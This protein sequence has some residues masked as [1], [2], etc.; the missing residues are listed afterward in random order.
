M[1]R[2]LYVASL[3]LF[4]THGAFADTSPPGTPAVPSAKVCTFP[5][6]AEVVLN[7]NKGEVD[8]VLALAR[9]PD[10][11]TVG[12][13]KALNAALGAQISALQAKYCK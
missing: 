8:A 11:M 7:V 3:A 4:F 13:L 2:I 12:Q 6:T 1:K 5:D 9:N 10:A